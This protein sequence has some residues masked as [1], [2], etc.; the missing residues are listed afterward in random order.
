MDRIDLLKTFVVV[1]NEGSFTN[2]ASKLDM[3]NQLV[4]KYI[5]QLE[6]RLD[7]RLFNLSLIHI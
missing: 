6:K 5:N 4:S 2:A 1:V 7:A 3:S